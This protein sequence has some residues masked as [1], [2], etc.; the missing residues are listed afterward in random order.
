MGTV[1]KQAGNGNVPIAP[2]KTGVYKLDG[3]PSE[4]KLYQNYEAVSTFAITPVPD[5]TTMNGNIENFRYDG[6]SVTHTGTQ[7]IIFK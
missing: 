2:G 6:N 3:I 1:F 5:F 4:G 7:T